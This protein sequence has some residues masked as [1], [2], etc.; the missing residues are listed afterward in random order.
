MSNTNKCG[1]TLHMEN[2]TW[3]TGHSWQVLISCAGYLVKAR[4]LVGA[5]LPM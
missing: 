3:K 4:T 2:R 5:L 1:V